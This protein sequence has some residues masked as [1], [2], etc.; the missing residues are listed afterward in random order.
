MAWILHSVYNRWVW[1]AGGGGEAGAGW[2]FDGRSVVLVNRLHWTKGMHAG[3]PS[4]DTLQKVL[5][6]LLERLE[7]EGALQLFQVRKPPPS[8]PPF[9]MPH[10][11]HC[12]SRLARVTCCV[13]WA[14]RPARAVVD[15][16][17]TGSGPHNPLV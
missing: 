15:G 13:G 7:P 6:L 16:V 8:L 4:E 11:P 5:P 10:C 17:A 9:W 12:L 1:D 14:S 3:G 2:G